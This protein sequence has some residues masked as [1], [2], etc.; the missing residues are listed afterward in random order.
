MG[1]AGLQGRAIWQDRSGAKATVAEKNFHA[2]F[3][4]A[5]QGTTFRIRPKPK[6][7]NNIYATVNLSP[8]VL[9]EIHNP[10]EAINRHGISPDYA[11]DNL[12]TEK[13]I[14][15]E[16]KR[17]DGWI[18]NGKRSDGRGNAHERSCKYFTP[19]LMSVLREHGKLGDSVIPFWTVFLGDITRDPCRVRE[20]TLWYKGCEDHFFLWRDPTNEATLLAHFENKIKPLLM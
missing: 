14:Y 8:A 17:Q 5:F 16:V 7:F 12:A 11:I 3:E 10:K 1:R 4:R 19:G 9:S 2:V 20:I 13:T 6:E 15:V 18:E